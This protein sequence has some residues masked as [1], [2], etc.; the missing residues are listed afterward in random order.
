MG[1]AQRA[2]PAKAVPRGSLVKADL[3]ITETA[4]EVQVEP[5]ELALV[6]AASDAQWLTGLDP[7]PVPCRQR[8]GVTLVGPLDRDPRSLSCSMLRAPLAGALYLK[9]GLVRT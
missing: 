2:G 4:S 5:I 6:V 7:G 3:E 8:D 9:R 1:G